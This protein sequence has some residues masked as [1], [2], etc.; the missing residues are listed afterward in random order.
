MSGEIPAVASCRATQAI[1]SSRA[2]QGIASCRA[3]QAVASGGFGIVALTLVSSS[4]ASEAVLTRN[5]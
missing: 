1:A 2:S 4:V 3:T 5:R